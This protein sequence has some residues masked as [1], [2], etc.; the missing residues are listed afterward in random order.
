MMMSSEVDKTAWDLEEIIADYQRRSLG[1]G[2]VDEGMRITE[3]FADSCR[4]SE[5]IPQWVMVIRA[6]AARIHLQQNRIEQLEKKDRVTIKDESGSILAVLHCNEMIVK[7]RNGVAVE[8]N[9]K[10]ESAT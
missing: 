7:E 1:A 2:T 4:N 3:N 8:V 9:G 5:P 6:M 10:E